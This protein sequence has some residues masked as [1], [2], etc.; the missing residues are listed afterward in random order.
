MEGGTCGKTGAGRHAVS[1]CMVCILRQ[2]LVSEGAS[3]VAGSALR[4]KR[5]SLDLRFQA[6]CKCLARVRLDNP[7][8]Q[9]RRSEPKGQISKMCD[10]AV[11]A[12]QD[13]KVRVL[14]VEL[15]DGAAS[16]SVLDQLQA[17]LKLLQTRLSAQA[18]SIIPGG[19]VIARKQTSQLK[20]ILR[21]NRSRLKFGQKVFA[22]Q[23]ERCG[24]RLCV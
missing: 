17:G 7:Q 22:P 8:A 2:R 23:V 13:T 15:K 11:I 9:Y 6:A 12:N 19:Y 24:S 14:V 20:H 10:F 16:R 3:L 1:A 21:S 5:C 4:E 18:V